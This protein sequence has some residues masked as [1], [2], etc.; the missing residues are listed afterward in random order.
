MTRIVLSCVYMTVLVGFGS[1]CEETAIYDRAYEDATDETDGDSSPDDTDGDSSPDDGDQ[2]D[3]AGEFDGPNRWFHTEDTAT[4]VDLVG[5]GTGIGDVAHNARVIDQFG[6]QVTLYQFYGQVVVLDFAAMWCGPCQSG[7]PEGQALWELYE[8]DGLV[9]ITAMMEDVQG[10]T[11]DVSDLA[12]WV[13]TYDLTHPV[14]R[15]DQGDLAGYTGFSYPRWIVIDR[16]MTITASGGWPFFN[17]EN[18][19][20]DL[21][22]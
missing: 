20:D 3:P 9:Y 8:P 10:A 7:A 15:D 11:P 14:L 17:I 16:T 12:Q 18:A 6:D 19:V 5:T 1:G 2:D 13:E 22:D 21:F 4:A